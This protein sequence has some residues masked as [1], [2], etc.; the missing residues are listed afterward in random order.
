MVHFLG[1]QRASLNENKPKQVVRAY[2]RNNALC[3]LLRPWLARRNN[4]LCGT[5]RTMNTT[6]TTYR[7]L[8]LAQLITAYQKPGMSGHERELLEKEI[9]RRGI[10]L[11]EAKQ[12]KVESLQE[13]AWQKSIN[14]AALRERGLKTF[15]RIFWRV[16][17]PVIAIF[18]IGY[19][20]QF[21]SWFTN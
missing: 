9:V 21:W 5:I 19:S 12:M 15:W 7:R 3:F 2:A 6:A 8:N 10:D 11:D 18:V 4:M 14:R 13:I 17:A 16:V 1:A 20:L